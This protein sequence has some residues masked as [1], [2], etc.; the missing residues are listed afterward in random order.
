MVAPSASAP[1]EAIP[2]WPD[3]TDAALRTSVL[4]VVRSRARA[5]RAALAARAEVLGGAS[6]LLGAAP[7]ARRTPSQRAFGIGRLVGVR[8]WQKARRSIGLARS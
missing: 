6:G 1:R 4:E 3:A 8:A 2:A 7:Q 5:D